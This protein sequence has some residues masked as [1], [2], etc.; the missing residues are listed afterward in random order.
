MNKSILPL[1]LIDAPCTSSLI[2]RDDLIAI[3]LLM[4]HLP[5]KLH[6]TREVFASCFIQ[7]VRTSSGRQYL[8]SGRN[9]DNLKGI[10]HPGSNF[11]LPPSPCLHVC[12][13]FVETFSRF[14][15]ANLL[16]ANS[17]ISETVAFVSQPSP[18]HS[19][20]EG[21]PVVQRGAGRQ[22]DSVLYSQRCKSRMLL[23]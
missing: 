4:L 6:A 17:V 1:P 22:S 5:H 9:S 23:A 3:V 18:N 7:S 13:P 20:P 21:H 11:S 10:H 2:K 16:N 8:D 19:A 12:L 15:L 14:T